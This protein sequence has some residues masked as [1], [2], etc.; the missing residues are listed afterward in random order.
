MTLRN[1]KILLRN[2][3]GGT[4]TMGTLGI[5]P[6]ATAVIWDTLTYDNDAF[7]NLQQ[8]IAGIAT[9]NQNIG[10]G[11]LVMVKNTVDQ[12]AAQAFSQFVDLTKAIELDQTVLTGFEVLR[13]ETSPVTDG[14]TVTYNVVG[15]MSIDGYEKLENLDD[16]A[17][18]AHLVDTSNPHEVTVEQLTTS[19]T[20]TNLVL[21]PDGYGDVTWG[22]G[23]GDVTGPGTHSDNVLPVLEGVDTNV[24]RTTGITINDSDEIDGVAQLDFAGA[25]ATAGDINL[26]DNGQI[27]SYGDGYARRL[28]KLTGGTLYIGQSTGDSLTSVEFEADSTYIFRLGSTVAQFTPT[29]V[30]FNVNLNMN[31]N[32]I[33]MGS[34]LVDGVDVSSHASRHEL[35]GADQ[36]DLTGLINLDGYVVGPGSA[37]DTAITLF[38]GTSGKLVK[39]SGITVDGSDNI[40]NAGTYNGV[41]VEAHASRHEAGGADEIDLTG[42]IDLDGYV[43]GPASSTDTALVRFDGTTGK[44]V[45]NSGIT[46]DGSDNITNAGTYNGVTVEA[47][48]SRHEFGGADQ[49]DLTGLID[50]DGYAT[51]VYVDGYIDNYLPLDGSRSM[52]GDLNLGSNDI[53]SPGA[54]TFSTIYT[55]ATT[56]TRGDILYRDVDNWAVLSAGDDGYVLTTHGTTNDPAWEPKGPP[57]LHA[58]THENGGADE[59]EISNMGTSETNTSYALKPDGYGGVVWSM[60]AG[61]GDVLGPGPTVTDNSIA[62]FD[63][64]GGYT[65]QDSSVTIDDDG[66]LWLDC[67]GSSTSSPRTFGFIN[68][69]SGEA[70]RWQLSNAYNGVQQQQAGAVQIYSYNTILLQGDRGIT[71]S[72]TFS[73]ESSIG[74]LVQNTVV[75]SPAL[76]VRGADSQTGDLQQWRDTESGDNVLVDIDSA[77]NLSIHSNNELRFYDNGNYVGFEAPAL[78]GDQIWVLP[79][80]DGDDGYALVT[81]GLGEL[82]WSPNG[83]VIGPAGGHQDNIVP[84]WD[85]YNT[86]TLQNSNLT[87]D[88]EG[89]M[90]LDM[91][92]T[93][94]IYPGG[95]IFDNF[96]SGNYYR[97]SFA[98]ND[99]QQSSYGG[100]V[101]LYAYNTIFIRGDREAGGAPAWDSDLTNISTIIQGTLAASRPLV[102][103]GADSQTANLQEWRDNP[104]SDTVLVHITSDGYVNLNDNDIQDVRTATFDGLIIGSGS[105]G[106]IN[107]PAGQKQ[108]WTMT[109]TGT[110]TFTAPAG[111]CNLMLKLINGGA[112]TITWPAAVDWAGGAEPS[113]TSSGTDIVAFFYDGT[114][115][116]GVGSLNFS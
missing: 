15:L 39:S 103:R 3:S 51:T 47:H 86:N 55:A 2:D 78:T 79:D 89:R 37:T 75:D 112:Y 17:I 76:V 26:P 101:T 13:L 92:S 107:W 44:L 62:R 5:D 80:A 27:Y 43:T 84:R 96:G 4:I 57:D 88:D 41:T 67:D 7:G 113:W 106:V 63:G 93:T 40:T 77:G 56:G 11:N 99:G 65:I 35:G 111:P 24:L 108:Q 98:D 6:A 49:I 34:G 9:F 104:T 12:T 83:D 69:S 59:I 109:G 1:L 50:L 102:V 30:D 94:S 18:N 28:M 36:I 115:Y 74:V 87:M 110:L 97:W 23:G 32:N 54:N 25:T 72:P 16:V 20:N 22:V 90:H 105:S 71:G 29:E 114:T 33:I 66:N 58:Y 10:N 95:L 60:T 53:T 73:T 21:K 91:A 52:T 100:A 45:Q 19:E 42:L 64:T 46:V 82:S 8:V 48:A 38:D 85:G 116:Y 70:V 68:F 61:S 14:V 31:N 81:N